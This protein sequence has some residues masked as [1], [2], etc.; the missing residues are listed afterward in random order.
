[1]TDLVCNNSEIA[2]FECNNGHGQ[3][4]PTWSAKA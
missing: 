3:F 2:G 4:I 1:M